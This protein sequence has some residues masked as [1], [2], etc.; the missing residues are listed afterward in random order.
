MHIW[1]ILANLVTY[2]VL[3]LSSC[4]TGDDYCSGPYSLTFTAGMTRAFLHISI[5]DDNLLEGDEYFIVMI[6]SSSLISGITVGSLAQVTVT[7]LDAD[8]TEVIL[9]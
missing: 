5:T 1:Q 2:F 7:I 4:F 3:R 8:G 9:T 6:D